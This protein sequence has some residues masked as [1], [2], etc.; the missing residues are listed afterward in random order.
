MAIAGV[1]ML[2]IQKLMGHR[3]IQSTMAYL[4][5]APDDLDAGVDRLSAARRQP[6]GNGKAESSVG[7]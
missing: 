2:T 6:G 5:L 3:T 7:A 4:H 1:P